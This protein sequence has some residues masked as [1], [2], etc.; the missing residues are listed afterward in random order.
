MASKRTRK[1][2]WWLLYA[3]IPFLGMLLLDVDWLPVPP[4]VHTALDIIA[5]LIAL[6]LMAIWLRA[7]RIAMVQEEYQKPDDPSPEEAPEAPS[8]GR[9]GGQGQ[10]P[11]H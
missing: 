6:G 1:P 5:V 7:N 10:A 3:L 2:A 9:K 8:R 4:I 11:K